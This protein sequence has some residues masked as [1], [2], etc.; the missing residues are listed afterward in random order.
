MTRFSKG[1]Y[2]KVTFLGIAVGRILCLRRELN[3]PSCCWC[4][5]GMCFHQLSYRDSGGAL[6]IVCPGF[7]ILFIINKYFQDFPNRKH[8]AFFQG[9][10]KF[11]SSG[12]IATLKTKIMRYKSRCAFCNS[13][14]KPKLNIMIKLLFYHYTS[15]CG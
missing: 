4:K 11:T 6:C 13:I 14:C 2:I 15:R 1:F 10:V 12:D 5:L 9:T 7:Q 8:V 3:P